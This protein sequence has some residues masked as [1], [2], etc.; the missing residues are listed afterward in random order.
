MFFTWHYTG[1]IAVGEEWILDSDS[2]FLGIPVVKFQILGRMK[3]IDPANF[4]GIDTGIAVDEKII[5]TVQLTQKIAL[6]V[7]Q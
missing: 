5:K 1:L 2:L 3:C 6:P 7:V 4:L